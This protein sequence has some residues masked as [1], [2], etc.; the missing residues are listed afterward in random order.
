MFIFTLPKNSLCH[1]LILPI[2]Q[3]GLLPSY[4]TVQWCNILNGLFCVLSKQ[5]NNHVN[6]LNGELQYILY[7]LYTWNPVDAAIKIVLWFL[8]KHVLYHI[9]QCCSW[10]P[11]WGKN[12]QFTCWVK[13]VVYWTPLNYSC[14]GQLCNVA[15]MNPDLSISSSRAL[16]GLIP[17]DYEL[18]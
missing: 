8:Q 12:K 16:G 15:V 17:L 6:W 14:V 13:V 9:S 4:C 1:V 7:I 10:L 3:S 18:L 11:V 2:V 5:E